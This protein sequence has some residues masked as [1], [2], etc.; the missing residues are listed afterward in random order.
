MRVPQTTSFKPQTFY[1]IV[2]AI[3]VGVAAG[4]ITAQVNPIIPLAAVIAVLPLPWLLTRPLVSFSAALAVITLL[5][6]ATLPF[7]VGLTPTFLEIALLLGWGVWA[8]GLARRPEIGLVRSPLDWGVL[9]LI[10]VSAFALLL[11]LSR[12]H[13]VSIVHN[14]FK[15]VLGITLYFLAFQLIRTPVALLWVMR[16]LVAG[17]AAA[18]ALGLV[19]WRLPDTL[20]TRILGALRVVGYPTDRI[21]R[22]VED[23]PAKGERATGTS[24]DPNSFGALLAVLVALTLAQAIARRPIFPRPLILLALA[25]E[26]VA[27]YATNSRSAL[28]AAVAAAGLIGLLRYRRLL[29]GGGVV[30]VAALALGLGGSYLARL[31]SGFALQDQAQLMRLAEYQNAITIIGRYPFFGV[32]FGT[33]GELDLTTG[34]SS[35]YL[36]IAE[37]MGLIG[38][39]VYLLVLGGFFVLTLSTL[40]KGSGT[41]DQGAGTRDQ[42]TPEPNTN[43]AVL[44]PQSSVLIYDP[45]L[46][47]ATAA[48]LAALVEGVADHPFFN[49]EYSHMV[50]LF[51]LCV[52]LALIA[53]RGLLAAQQAHPPL[54]ESTA[55]P[56]AIPQTANRKLQTSTKEG[57]ATTWPK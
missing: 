16:A 44:S 4:A 38:L 47:G 12:D 39:G 37:R 56:N 13:D 24:V 36:T 45:V 49:I 17:G 51:W 22:Y 15:T 30:A 34:V 14:Y 33:A 55:A 25:V 3:G 19:L 31:Q 40:V 43:P 9:L 46:L 23:D 10:G 5:P 7:K 54:T 27:I 8:V 53:R 42:Q 2:L 52:A 21:I 28:L 48:V 11:G 26:G 1:A 20:A 6:F 32:G 18:A 41:R 57:A 35:I 50:A 29:I